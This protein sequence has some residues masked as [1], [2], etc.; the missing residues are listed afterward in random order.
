[1]ETWLYAV[2]AG[3]CVLASLATMIYRWIDHNEEHDLD[4]GKNPLKVKWI[5]MSLAAIATSSAIIEVIAYFTPVRPEYAVLAYI[6]MGSLGA[7]FATVFTILYNEGLSTLIHLTNQKV[8]KTVDAL[9]SKEAE[10]L[11][12]NISSLG[13]IVAD[14]SK[15]IES[16]A[17]V[18][19]DLR[20]RLGL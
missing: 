6:L 11:K 3:V 2:F 17:Q 1:M 12:Q 18:I 15:T 5:I 19:A 8:K 7:V 10:E 9:Q 16:Q 4:R 14:Q 20:S 13:A